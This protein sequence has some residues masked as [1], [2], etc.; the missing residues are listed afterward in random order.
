MVE[1]GRLSGLESGP[2]GLQ[3]LAQVLAVAPVAGQQAVQLQVAMALSARKRAL[4]RS[5]AADL[6]ELDKDPSAQE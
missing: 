1:S 6:W 2:A 3:A 5:T 4:D